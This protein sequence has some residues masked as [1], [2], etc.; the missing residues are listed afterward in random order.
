MGEPEFASEEGGTTKR[1]EGSIYGGT[2]VCDSGSRVRVFSFQL[3]FAIVMHVGFETVSYSA[4]SIY[5]SSKNYEPR[6]SKPSRPKLSYAEFIQ[7]FVQRRTCK[8]PSPSYF[9]C[10]NQLT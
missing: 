1:S 7:A 4:N 6:E 3:T 10:P 8:T 5:Q 9:E 2:E